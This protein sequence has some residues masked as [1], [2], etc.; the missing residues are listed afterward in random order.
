MANTTNASM[1]EQTMSYGTV[2]AEKM[3]TESGYS[4]G[5]GN[6]SSFKNRIINGE[7]DIDQRNNGAAISSTSGGTFAVDRFASFSNAGGIYTT[8]RSTD[9]PSGQG[10]ANSIVS[11]VTTTDSPT[12]TDYYIIQ[13]TIEG[14]NI[15]DLMWGTANAKPVT[16]SFW[17]KSSIP[18]LYT[19]AFRN[20]ANNRSYRATYTINAANTWEFETVSIP[21]D[22]TGTWVIDSGQGIKLGFTLG[23]GPD[24]ID[25][26]NVWSAVEDFAATGQV[27]W[28]STSGATFF[29]TGV[30]F[31][32]G[33]VATSYDFRSIG[34]ELAL[35]QR[36]YVDLANN[37]GATQNSYR[38]IGFCATYT[39]TQGS[40]VAQV[41]VPM[42]TLPSLTQAGT[43]YLQN[44][45]TTSVSSFAG[46]YSMAG[47]II[48][49]DFT[50]VGAVTANITA[51]LRWNNSSTQRFAYSAEL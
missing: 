46:P 50:M 27:Q 16:V 34:T 24:F 13:Q 33:T 20:S 18:G 31:E 30:Q 28:I 51:I 9:V 1:G 36:Y 17:V 2:Q 4:L 38:A 41:P 3:T 29:L 48:E 39:T 12:G 35:C 19:V 15:A 37:G 7:M 47:T 44:L 8:Q 22:T 23:A 11:T 42:R 40:Y 5:A 21:G 49:G 6:A 43:M 10:F 14:F 32:V 26:G 45:G 25:T